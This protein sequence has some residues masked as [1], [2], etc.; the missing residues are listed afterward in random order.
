MKNKKTAM[1]SKDDIIYA[2][3]VA[4]C[5]QANIIA[6][7]IK[8]GKAKT[9]LVVDTGAAVNVLSEKA[10]H[11]LKRAFRGSRLSLRPNELNLM[12][13]DSGLLNI[14]GIVRLPISLGKSTSIKR[15]DFYVA[16]NFSLSP[17]RLI[18]LMSMK[19]NKMEIHP[20]SNLIRYQNKSFKA[21]DQP[22][23]L[24][25]GSDTICK[26]YKGTLKLKLCLHS[27]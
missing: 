4:A 16:S 12:N 20:N 18:G 11:A 3:I 15:L 25:S 5:S 6:L 27:R 23:C 1:I 13:V 17:D 22:M 8:M 9:A 2:S 24:A 26:D 19:S 7:S 10:Y 21:M 14:L